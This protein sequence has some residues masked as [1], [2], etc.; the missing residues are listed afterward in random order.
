MN[1]PTF[2]I[3][4]QVKPKPEWISNPNN[5]PSGLIIEIAPWGDEGAFYIEGERR[6]FAAYV[7]EKV[8]EMN[9]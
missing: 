6:A 4:D 9:P 2:K 8:T 1:S 3:G 7:F 5:I